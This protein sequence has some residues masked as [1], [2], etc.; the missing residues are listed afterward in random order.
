MKSHSPMR[1]QGFSLLEMVVAVAILGLALGALYQSVGGATR[2]VRADQRYAYAV[3]LGRSLIADNSVVPLEGLQKTGETSGGFVW[4]VVASPLERARGSALGGGRL[5]L[6]DV[7][8]SWPDG[9]RQRQI[10][11]SSVVAGVQR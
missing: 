11:L 9:S 6:I 1:Q 5:Q 4:E 10:T 3:E 2:N 7:R 8:V